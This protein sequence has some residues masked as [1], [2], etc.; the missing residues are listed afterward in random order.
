MQ[1]IV[2]RVINSCWFCFKWG[3]VLIVL[4]AA[5][6]VPYFHGR[7]N[8]EIRSR[9]QARIAGQYPGLKVTIRSAT[10]MKGEG[11]AFR[12]L[13]ILESGAE[14][15]N[16]ELLE[17][18][19][20]I[21]HCGT[22]LRDLLAGDL[23]VSRVT[24]RRPTLRLTRRPNGA[25]SAARLLPLPKFSK[26]PHPTTI[27]NGTVE[28]FDPLKTPASTLTL[29][30]VNLTLTPMPAAPDRPA[31]PSRALRGSL[32]GDYFR[33]VDLQGMIDPVRSAFAVNGS[34]EGLEI[35]TEL[36]DA[37]PEPIA[38][39]LCLLSEVR[40]QGEMK[41]QVVHDPAAATALQYSL[42]GRITRGRIDDP[43]LPHPLTDIHALRNSTTAASR[44]RI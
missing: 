44:S 22:N 30:D 2:A 4:G 18:D 25:W 20:C 17:V 24:V 26:H 3:V 29:R 31:T 28:I 10:V 5:L 38:A 15:P 6:A 12:G 8:E 39:K 36:R 33:N 19:E 34:V 21:L 27:E 9:I 16:A 43:R 23:D 41:F 35:C 13:S 37:L 32:S 14:G 40:G 7:M 1:A 11:I 42:Q